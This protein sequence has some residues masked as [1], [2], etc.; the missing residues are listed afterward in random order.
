MPETFD[1]P[2]CEPSPAR[3][4]GPSFALALAVLALAGCTAEAPSP[5]DS[6]RFLVEPVRLTHRV[7]FAGGS[8]ELSMAEQYELSSFL[9]QAD[10]E[11]RATIYLDAHGQE[12]MGRIGIVAEALGALG[13]ES[14][15]TGG[16]QG[17]EHGVTVTLLQDVVIPEVCLGGD[18]WPQP[19]L[20]PAGCTQALTLVQMVED[21]DDLLRGRDMGP[22]LSA[23]AAGA[24][25]RHFERRATQAPADER[26]ASVD[27]EAMPELPSAPITREASY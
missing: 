15:G 22:A 5:P 3:R 2:T 27:P 11:G 4:R 24:A 18:G 13:R 21:Q 10:P 7:A 1:C 20:A 12:K 16:G 6:D 19:Q 9:D 23:T 26:P 25:L 17:T 14:A 8:R